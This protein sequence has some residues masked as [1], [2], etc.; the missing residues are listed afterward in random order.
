MKK[1]AKKSKIDFGLIAFYSDG[2]YEQGNASEKLKKRIN[3]IYEK[4]LSEANNDLHVSK[5][6]CFNEKKINK[7][8]DAWASAVIIFEKHK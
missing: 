1:N 6:V 4:V 2:H 3:K 8:K 5:Y 7:N